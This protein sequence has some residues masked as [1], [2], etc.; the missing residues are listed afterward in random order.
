MS[1]S[2][3]W[4]SFSSVICGSPNEYDKSRGTESLKG[5]HFCGGAPFT[6]PTSQ[7]CCSLSLRKFTLSWFCSYYLRFQNLGK[8]IILHW[9]TYTCVHFNVLCFLERNPKEPINLTCSQTTLCLERIIFSV[10]VPWN[11]MP[12]TLL[13]LK[14]V[15]CSTECQLH[16]HALYRLWQY[17]THSAR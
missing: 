11:C 17:P 15:Q 8:K 12:H 7:E 10:G 1:S 14:C 4:I 6:F 9:F 16:S 5:K 13:L 2:C 3:N